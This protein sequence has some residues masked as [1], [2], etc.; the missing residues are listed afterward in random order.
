MIDP[1][2]PSAHRMMWTTLASPL[3]VTSP[4]G[5]NEGHG[6]Q[7]KAGDEPLLEAGAPRTLEAV[8][9]TAMILMEILCR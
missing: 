2:C 9:S 1:A 5:I 6:H 4:C 3:G 8:G 7:V